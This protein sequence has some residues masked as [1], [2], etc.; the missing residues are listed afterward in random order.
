MCICLCVTQ[1]NYKIHG[2]MI[3]IF[4]F[5][6]LCVRFIRYSF[7]GYNTISCN[8]LIRSKIGELQNSTLHTGT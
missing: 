1:I 3:K 4:F 7:E 2:A 6:I 8:K 5:N